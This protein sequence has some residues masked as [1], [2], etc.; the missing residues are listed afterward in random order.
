MSDKP[1]KRKLFSFSEFVNMAN[2]RLANTEVDVERR[3]ALRG[4]V[5][6]FLRANGENFYQNSWDEFT[7]TGN[8]KFP[9]SLLRYYVNNLL[10]ISHKNL[11]YKVQIA[12]LLEH[13]LMDTGNYHGFGYN[14]S[15]DSMW[16]ERFYYG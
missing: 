12:N 14:I 6:E 3:I 13:I 1:R 7:Y 15:D 11:T 4:F 5:E 8:N 10:A 2:E 9:V 16:T